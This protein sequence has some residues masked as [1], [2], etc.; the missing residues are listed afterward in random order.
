MVFAST[1]VVNIL[2]RLA[3]F[4]ICLPRLLG[5]LDQLIQDLRAELDAGRSNPQQLSELKSVDGEAHDRC[6]RGIDAVA[7]DRPL[8]GLEALSHT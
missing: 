6:T 1:G 5:E 7:L 8:P 3:S 4:L 2:A